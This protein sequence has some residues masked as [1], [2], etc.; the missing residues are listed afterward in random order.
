[1]SLLVIFIGPVDKNKI[2]YKQAAAIGV[3][4]FS[5]G[6]K[7]SFPPSFNLMRRSDTVTD[8]DNFT[9][10]LMIEQEALPGKDWQEYLIKNLELDSLSVDTIPSGM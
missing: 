2:I 5:S 8:D 9:C 6:S 1:M 7:D 4:T 10:I 3:N